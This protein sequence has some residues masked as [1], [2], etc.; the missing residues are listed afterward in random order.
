MGLLDALLGHA[1]AVDTA[2]VQED[3]ARLLAPQ[4]RVERAYGLIRDLFVFTDRRLL[5]IDKQGLTGSKVSYHSIPYRAITQFTVETAG[6][7]DLDAELK[8]WVSGGGTAPVVSK[9]FGKSLSVYEV[10]GVLAG[11]LR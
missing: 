10:Q 8:I 5:M 2:K 11:Y 6:H 3:L 4:E 7:F 1:S 9:T